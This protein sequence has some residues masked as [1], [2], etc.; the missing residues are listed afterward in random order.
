MSSLTDKQKMFCMEFLKDLNATQA[1][2]RAGYSKKTARQIATENLSKPFIQDYIAT[3][4]TERIEE[5][6]TDANYVLKRLLEIDALDVA[7]I[8]DE[9]GDLIPV[10][11]WPKVWR[12]SVNAIEIVQMKSTEDVIAYLKKIKIPDKIKNLELLGK[13]IDV[14]AFKDKLELTGKDGGELIINVTSNKTKEGLNKLRE[15]LS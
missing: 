10:K 15:S 13:H 11:D 12:T 6:K 5:V 7:D 4:K 14:S 1:A 3:L 8:V 9:S 2:I